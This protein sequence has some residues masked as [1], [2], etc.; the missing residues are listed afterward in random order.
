MKVLM[1]HKLDR[2][3]I[4]I[5]SEL[6][7]NG[8]ITNVNLAEK[9]G[10]SASPCLKRVKRLEESKYVVRYG[11]EIDYSKLGDYVVIFT[12][13]TLKQHFRHSFNDFENFLKKYTEVVECHLISGGYDYLV[14]FIVKNISHYQSVVEEILSDESMVRE[15]FSYIVIKTPIDSRSPSLEKTFI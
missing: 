13:F 10:L 5:L 7:K 1:D 9:V 3:D 4:R 8:R 6:Q 15:Y 2:I 12:E 14:K 11:A